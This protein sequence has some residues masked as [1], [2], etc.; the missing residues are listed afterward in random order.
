MNENRSFVITLVLAIMSGAAIGLIAFGV[1]GKGAQPVP[2]A[3][4]SPDAN[5]SAAPSAPSPSTQPAE[6][7]AP[8]QY[9]A[10]DGGSAP[11]PPP[12][13]TGDKDLPPLM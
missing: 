7:M 6:S 13:K 12:Q 4:A 8:V 1:T 10:P 11:P 2:V 9:D 3:V 5:T